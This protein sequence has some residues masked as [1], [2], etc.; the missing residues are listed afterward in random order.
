MKG[1]EQKW[2]ETVLASFPALIFIKVTFVYVLNVILVMK[3]LVCA[4]H[5]K[6]ILLTFNRFI[7][8]IISN[9]SPS[10]QRAV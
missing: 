7:I 6:G 10:K 4:Q 1:M 8:R 5:V 3:D 9:D 2:T